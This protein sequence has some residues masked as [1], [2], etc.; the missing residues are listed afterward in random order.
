MDPTGLVS[1]IF[2]ATKKIDA[3][4]KGFATRGK[5]AEGRLLYEE[6]IALAMTVFKE[7]QATGDPFIMLLVESAYIMQERELCDKSDKDTINSL[8]KANDSLEDAFLA[9]QAVEGSCYRAVDLAT[10]HDK[11]F[12]FKD[13]PK[14]AF[15]IACSSHKTRLQNIIRAPGIDPIE[16]EL[17]KQRIVNL[18]VAQDGYLEKQIKAF[19]N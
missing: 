6:G 1:N 4:R 12:R 14:D 9:L 18:P 17:L 11:K 5:E 8:T 2:N 3:G 10:P 16:K 7:A 15:H 19:L 13:Y